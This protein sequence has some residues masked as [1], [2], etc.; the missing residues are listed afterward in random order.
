ML[1]CNENDLEESH[2][3]E[4]AHDATDIESQTRSHPRLDQYA[5]TVKKI[6]IM[7]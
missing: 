5:I 3:L 2:D 7:L 6:Y 1:I 4:E